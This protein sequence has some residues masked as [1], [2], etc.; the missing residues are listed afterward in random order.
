MIASARARAA[1]RG[2]RCCR[3]IAHLPAA[4]GFAE[5]FVMS[6]Q[7][8]KTLQTFANPA[9]GRDYHIHMQVPEF[10]CLCPL[11]GQPDFAHFTIEIVADELAGELEGGGFGEG[12]EA[13]E[14][15]LIQP[16]GGGCKC[17]I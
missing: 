4:P 7:P 2:P 17:L 6:T 11:T 1:V 10:T 12:L 9:P 16:H 15:D 5:S 3:I 8:S 14:L 13:A